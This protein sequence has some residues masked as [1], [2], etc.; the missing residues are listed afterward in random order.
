MFQGV[1]DADKMFFTIEVGGKGKQCDEGT[2]AGSRLF[3]LLERNEFNVLPDQEL[4]VTNTKLP[5]III[6]DEACPLKE[7]LMRP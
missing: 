5:N 7:Y 4:S 2:F 3:E 1:A 6:G